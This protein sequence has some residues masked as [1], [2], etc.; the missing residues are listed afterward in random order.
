MALVAIVGFQR[1]PDQ[2]ARM[3]SHQII[4]LRG[5]GRLPVAGRRDDGRQPPGA[6]TLQL[7]QQI[8]APDML[9]AIYRRLKT[10]LMRDHISCC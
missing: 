1:Q 9:A 4:P 5:E 3:V 2:F 6:Q 7:L 10:A 8:A